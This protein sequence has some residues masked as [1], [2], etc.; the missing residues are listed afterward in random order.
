MTNNRAQSLDALRETFGEERVAADIRRDRVRA[1]FDRIAPRYDLMNDLMSFGTHRLWKRA[2]ARALGAALP[3]VSGPVVD[4]AGGTG[5]LALLLRRQFPDRR[6]VVVDA[7]AGMLEVA[8][9]RAAGAFETLRAEAESLPF[10][11]SSVAAV[12]LAFGLRNMTDP[13][14]VLAETARVL[15]P[16]GLLALLEFS[17]ADRWFAPAYGLHSRLVIPALGALVARDREAYRYLVESIR[18]FPDASAVSSE[19]ETAGLAV[20]GVRRFMFGV[21][22]F[23]LARKP[24]SGDKTP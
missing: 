9:G 17:Q 15:R 14:A 5:D 2:V 1:L 19:L 8:R 3:P 16:G 21:A 18:I 10:A 24:P 20:L 13:A 4:L 7:S 23:H 11:D 6:I 12:S 22:A